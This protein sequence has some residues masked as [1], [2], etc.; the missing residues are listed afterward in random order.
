MAFGSWRGTVGLI[1]PTMRAGNLEELIRIL[2]IG[3]SVIPL[4]NAIRDGTREKFERVI[5][6]YEEKIA[7]FAAEGI[8]LVHPAGA[9]PFMVLGIER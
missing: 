8:E 9:P 2:P 6:G 3:I 4:F 1:K 7:Q 5:G